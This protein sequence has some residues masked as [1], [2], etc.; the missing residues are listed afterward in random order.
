[1]DELTSE[2]KFINEEEEI[3]R[4][5]EREPFIDWNDLD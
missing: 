5:E 2:I 4:E 3:E 1:M